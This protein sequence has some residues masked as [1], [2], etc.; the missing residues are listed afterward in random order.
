MMRRASGSFFAGSV[1]QAANPRS[2][3]VAERI[4]MRFERTVTLAPT[5]RRGAIEGSLFW[6]TSSQWSTRDRS[7]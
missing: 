2:V 3:R 4:G 1:P 5:E 7:T 6:I